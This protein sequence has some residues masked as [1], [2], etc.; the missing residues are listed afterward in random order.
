ML[1]LAGPVTLPITLKHNRACDFA[2]GNTEEALRA[3]VFGLSERG[4]KAQGALDRCTGR[5]W[6]RRVGDGKP[7]DYADAFARADCTVR[8]G[9]CDRI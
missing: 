3:K 8:G 4:E 6:V 5:G 9:V 1:D 2:F 7:G